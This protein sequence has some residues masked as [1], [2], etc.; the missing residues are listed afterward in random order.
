MAGGHLI[1]HVE[2]HENGV[3]LMTTP[4]GKNFKVTS[5]HHQMFGYPLPDNARLLGWSTEKYSKK[6]FEEL[7]LY[8]WSFHN[9]F[10]DDENCNVIRYRSGSSI[11]KSYSP[12]E[13][14]NDEPEF[15][16][17]VV[18]LPSINS[19]AVQY[20]PEM[21]PVESSGHQYY[22]DLIQSCLGVKKIATTKIAV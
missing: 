11:V 16:P 3:H 22:L 10:K 13:P 15:E 4:E 19:L 12:Y 9:R 1:Q 2:G 17:E 20:H 5:L 7:A 14:H 21:M 6:A 8:Q 18:Y